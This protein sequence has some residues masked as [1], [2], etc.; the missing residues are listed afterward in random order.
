M[1]GKHFIND[2]IE[3]HSCIGRFKQEVIEQYC[4][5]KTGKGFAGH[6]SLRVFVNYLQRAMSI[7]ELV[8]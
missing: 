4:S 6:F 3:A 5:F 8:Y 2:L 7:C 1:H